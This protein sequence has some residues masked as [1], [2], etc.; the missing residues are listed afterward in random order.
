MTEICFNAEPG[1]LKAVEKVVDTYTPNLREE[2]K[3]SLIS[4]LEAVAKETVENKVS[5]HEKNKL[6]ELLGSMKT[7]C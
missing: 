6:S 4:K 1:I 3:N 2:K 7:V 5:S